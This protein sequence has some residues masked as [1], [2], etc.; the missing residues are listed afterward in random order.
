MG[1]FILQHNVASAD[2]ITQVLQVFFSC[3]EKG[4]KW[5]DFGLKSALAPW[6]GKTPKRDSAEITSPFPFV[7]LYKHG[8]Q[9]R[10]GN[11]TVITKTLTVSP[12]ARRSAQSDT[13]ATV[14][15]VTHAYNTLPCPLLFLFILKNAQT[16]SSSSEHQPS[17]MFWFNTR[18]PKQCQLHKA[19]TDA[20]KLLSLKNKNETKVNGLITYTIPYQN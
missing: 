6:F 20:S 2:F 9:S 5:T 10:T 14:I 13:A 12:G 1:Y 17:Q 3:L 8:S 16:C 18:Y 4:K 19:S 7:T 15:T 11:L